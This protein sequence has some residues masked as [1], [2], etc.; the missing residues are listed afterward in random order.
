MLPALAW[1]G[2][3]RRGERENRWPCRP[4]QQRL[5]NFYLFRPPQAL[6]QALPMWTQRRLP[7]MPP[8][9]RH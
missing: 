6:L 5:E 7:S 4:V 3:R 1:G 8:P 9:R 2:L